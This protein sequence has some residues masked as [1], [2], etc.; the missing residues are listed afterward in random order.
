MTGKRYPAR[1]R[2]PDGLRLGLLEHPAADRFLQP[3]IREL[4]DQAVRRLRAGGADVHPVGIADLDLASDTLKAILTPEASVVHQRLVAAEP[5]GFSATTQLQIEAG[6][7]VPATAYVRAQQLRRELAARF[8]QLF[9]GVDALLSPTVPWVAP[10]EDPL[11]GDE[12]GE[13]EM[14]Y[15][16]VHNLVGLPALS[17]PCGL[18]AE[19]LPAGLQISGPWRADDLVLGIGAALEAILPRLAPPL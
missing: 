16:A 19:G 14:L 5:D 2:Q 10:A 9:A 4:I 17:L 13:G 8:R 12:A 11:I 18:S 6:F 1:P 3:A 7:A 15:S